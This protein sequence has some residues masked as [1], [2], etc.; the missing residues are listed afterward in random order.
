MRAVTTLPY[1]AVIRRLS[2]SVVSIHKQKG[3]ECGCV[4]GQK[5]VFRGQHYLRKV[6]TMI[7]GVV[8]L[9]F[10]SHLQKNK[11]KGW[12]QRKHT[13]YELS[14]VHT[15]TKAHWGYLIHMNQCQ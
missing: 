10:L 15:C 3:G 11:K 6:Q 14:L 2:L 7:S 4:A 8:V 13:D 12:K 5:V 9:V 1:M